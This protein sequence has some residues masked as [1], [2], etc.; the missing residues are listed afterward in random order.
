MLLQ[1]FSVQSYAAHVHREAKLARDAQEP[2]EAA[3][4]LRVVRQPFYEKSSGLS[5]ERSGLLR[6]P[7]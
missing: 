4:R 2:T 7:S 1:P 6:R 3:S 5:L